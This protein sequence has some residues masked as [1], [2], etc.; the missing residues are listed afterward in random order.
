MQCIHSVH[1]VRWQFLCRFEIQTERTQKRWT[2]I[3]CKCKHTKNTENNRA[4]L[5]PSL[6]VARART[7]T[8]LHLN[9]RETGMH[10]INHIEFSHIENRKI[11]MHV[12]KFH[13][14]TLLSTENYNLWNATTTSAKARSH[15]QN[16]DSFCRIRVPCVC[17]CSLFVRRLSAVDFELVGCRSNESNALQIRPLPMRFDNNFTHCHTIT[18]ADIFFSVFF[19]VSLSHFLTVEFS[20]CTAIF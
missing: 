2:N 4:S 16:I 15:T 11:L 19:F 20:S 13:L 12:A 10:T 18:I 1:V 14:L 5:S 7:L 3:T 8:R 9:E 6:T 17:E